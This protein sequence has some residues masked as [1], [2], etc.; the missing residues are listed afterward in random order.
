[1]IKMWVF[2]V[3]FW[4]GGG[5]NK[6]KIIKKEKGEKGWEFYYLTT[7]NYFLFGNTNTFLKPE[8]SVML[9]AD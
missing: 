5:L 3:F 4:G 7:P 2:F 9:N 8:V 1:M 6:K